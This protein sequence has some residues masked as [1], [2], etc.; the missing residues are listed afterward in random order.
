MREFDQDPFASGF[1]SGFAMTEATTLNTVSNAGASIR[2]CI[3]DMI[4]AR[5]RNQVGVMVAEH[6][7]HVHYPT[8]DGKCRL[9]GASRYTRE[10]RA[11]AFACAIRCI[12]CVW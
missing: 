1:A 11:C 5:S 8:H 6:D 9:E 10:A 2:A 12:Y 3:R 7:R 4:C